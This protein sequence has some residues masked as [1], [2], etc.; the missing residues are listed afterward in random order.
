MNFFYVEGALLGKRDHKPEMDKSF[1]EEKKRLG[2]VKT[3]GVQCW[4]VFA[5]APYPP[6]KFVRL[7]LV[8]SSPKSLHVVVW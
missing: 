3:I 6:G 2:L 4:Q 8:L 1:R 7:V 5:A